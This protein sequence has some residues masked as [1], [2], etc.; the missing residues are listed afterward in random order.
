MGGLDHIFTAAEARQSFRLHS[1]GPEGRKWIVRLMR[2]I[3]TV[4][5][6]ERKVIA[7]LPPE[8]CREMCFYLLDELGYTVH[9]TQ[10]GWEVRWR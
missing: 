5:I 10:G 1:M 9:N 4:S 3:E 7:S 2:E 8:E 6:R